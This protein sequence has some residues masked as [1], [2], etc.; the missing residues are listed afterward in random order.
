MLTLSQTENLPTGKWKN[1]NLYLC[2]I[3]NKKRKLQSGLKCHQSN[4]TQPSREEILDTASLLGDTIVDNSQQQISSRLE[5]KIYRKA[6]IVKILNAVYDRV[7][8]WREYIFLL[9]LSK[10]VL[11]KH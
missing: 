9:P 6:H 1:E 4:C 5:W 3:C 11:K 2:D 10:L 7:V 8:L